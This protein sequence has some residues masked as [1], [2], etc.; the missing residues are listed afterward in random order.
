MVPRMAVKPLSRGSKRTPGDRQ[1]VRLTLGVGLA[2][3]LLVCVL[4]TTGE[5]DSPERW[6]SDRRARDCQFFLPAAGDALVH[7]DIDDESLQAV[8]RWPWPR[9]TLAGLLDEVH[10][11][12]PRVVALD[13]LLTD[14]QTPQT[15]LREDGSLETVDHDAILADVVKRSGNVI[16]PVAFGLASPVRSAV[17]VE[18]Y[19]LLATDPDMPY[20]E[21]VSK[22]ISENPL[23]PTE[24]PDKTTYTGQRQR[25][26][27]VQLESVLTADPSMELGPTVEKIMGQWPGAGGFAGV[28]REFYPRV[29]SLAL[30]R[31]SSLPAEVDMSFAYGSGDAPPLPMLAKASA[32]TC[33]VDYLPDADGASRMIPIFVKRGDRIYPT[34]GLAM[35]CRYL[36]VSL[37][38]LRIDRGRVVLP[39]SDGRTITIPT[40]TQA[41]PGQGEVGHVIPIPWF[42]P[43]GREGDWDWQTMYDMPDYKQ[44]AQHLSMAYVHDLLRL[45]EAIPHNSQVADDAIA[46]VLQLASVGLLERYTQLKLPDD[47]D[48]IVDRLTWIDKTLAEAQFMA[49]IFSEMTDDDR[50]AVVQDYVNE[51]RPKLERVRDEWLAMTPNNREKRLAD[52]PSD[53]RDAITKLLTEGGLAEQLAHYAREREHQID[54]FL[55]SLKVLPEVSSEFRKYLQRRTELRTQLSGRA[56]LVGWTATGT[57]D[58]VPTPLHR[59]CPG[60]ICHGVVFHGIVSGELWGTAP[61]WVATLLTLVFGL[62]VTLWTALATPVRSLIVAVGVAVFYWCVNGIVLFDLGNTIVGVAGPMLAIGLAWPACTLTRYLVESAERQRVRDRFANYVDP[63]LVDYVLE[64]RGMARLQGETR[65]LTVVFTDLAGFTTITEKL[66]EATVPLLNDYMGLMVPL[67]REQGGYVNKFLG[68]GIMFFYGAPR[69]NED[70]AAAAVRTVLAMQEAVVKFNEMLYTRQLPTVKVR[71]G[72]NTGKMVVGDA[73]PSDASDYTVLGDEVNLSARLESANKATG[74]LILIGQRT[75]ELLNGR[76][77]LKPVGRLQVVGK[78]TGVMTYEPMALLSDATHEQREHV[79]LYEALLDHFTHRRFMECLEAIARVRE[80]TGP[81]KLADLYEKLCRQYLDTPPGKEFDGSIVL[82]SK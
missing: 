49:S 14:P 26:A 1:P 69:P 12:G 19:K 39:L 67:I 63:A 59:R 66:G 22:L 53:Q 18:T 57:T 43:S 54:V 21:L 61:V 72:V 38:Q 77:L 41:M 9:A 23:G 48:H 60:V 74:T 46:A 3:T 32:G 50:K 80:A 15:V 31:S 68:D 6:L 70:H 56:V 44:T 47:A 62:I 76:Y 71:C 28:L 36:G 65:E 52:L 42:G 10:R 45:E 79:A 13:I 7:L 40:A 24:K 25:L 4:D 33:S 2:M 58:W 37:E 29:K 78:T 16:L 8:G 81:G 17:E 51:Q 27:L 20:E 73:G 35:A 34:L 11:A 64:N 5:L 55:P 82:E 30:L 75:A